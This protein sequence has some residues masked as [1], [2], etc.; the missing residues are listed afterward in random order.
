MIFNKIDDV[1]SIAIFTLVVVS[2]ISLADSAY[3]TPDT[4]PD[5]AMMTSDDEKNHIHPPLTQHRDGVFLSAIECNDPHKLYI[6]NAS[7]PVC[8]QES[9]YE[10][11]LERGID[12]TTYEESS[13]A[14]EIRTVTVGM[15]A[16]LTGG[17]FGYGQDISA[18]A[19][20]AVADFNT[21][22]EERGE[23]WRLNLQRHDTMTDG[24]LQFEQITDLHRLGVNIVAGPSIDTFDGRLLEYANNNNML[25]LSCCSSVLSHAINNDALFRFV[26]TLDKHGYAVAEVMD[27]AGIK[28]MITAGRDAVWITDLTDS[29]KSKFIEL[30]GQTAEPSI[31]Y[32]VSGEFDASHTQMLADAVSLHL[33]SFD[34]QDVGV[35]FVGF[36]ETFDF[37]ELASSH[38][39]LDSVRWFGSD[40]NTIIHDNQ[41]GLVFAEKVGFTV[42][43]PTA[44]E[45]DLKTRIA[46]QIS[47][48]LE[49]TP[50]VYAFLEY[51]L[52]QI[53]GRTI[54]DAQSTSTD[55]IVNR[56]PTTAQEYVGVSGSIMLNDAGDRSDIG[57]AVWSVRNGVWTDALPVL[58]L[59]IQEL[60]WLESNPEIK[61]AY[62]PD[63]S[64]FEYI[65]DD[66]TL[67]GITPQLVSEFER[68]TNVDF[69]PVLEITSWSEVL[70]RL[71]NRTADVGFLIVNTPERSKYLDFTTPYRTITTDIV[72]VGDMGVTLD[73]LADFRVATIQEFEIDGWFAENYPKADQV[74]V[75]SMQSALEMLQSGEVDVFLESWDVVSYNADILEIT[76]LYN[77]GATGHGFD[78]SVASRNDQPLLGSILQKTLDAVDETAFILEEEIVEEEDTEEQE[79]N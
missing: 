41:N 34:P 26:P 15:L 58:N 74:S 47:T 9:T 72:T 13:A 51:D 78:L 46:Q 22:L 65:R 37:L 10:R 16:P 42:V 2:G 67:G 63:W 1:Y 53:L 3:A 33:E 64:P 20:L 39:V 76:G 68:L 27:D 6:R 50:S 52:V 77:A 45:S 7:S 61:V 21:L 79:E 75:N 59:T 25:L 23:N 69:V 32:D 29:A 49:R 48:T 54:L 57:Y 14:N 38:D 19:D 66:G 18:G 56:V 17:A 60:Q 43:Q 24:N 11:L 44:P 28:V 73:N 31:L 5:F 71:E 40:A 30:G 70:D 36:E 12:L 55:D 4:I 35:L 8:I 62:I